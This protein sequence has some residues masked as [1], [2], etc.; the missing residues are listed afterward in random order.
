MTL[1]G[2]H[3]G[4]DVRQLVV[5]VGSSFWFWWLEASHMSRL[6]IVLCACSVAAQVLDELQTHLLSV[7]NI[8]NYLRFKFSLYQNPNLLRGLGSGILLNLIPEP[9]V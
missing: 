8:E 4:G 6:I 2:C 5:A 3:L 1:F 7:C 9:Q